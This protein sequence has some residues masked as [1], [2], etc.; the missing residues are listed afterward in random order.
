MLDLNV[1]E[2]IVNAVKAIGFKELTEVQKQVIP[3]VM[4][5]KNVVGTSQTGSGKTHSFLIPLFDQLRFMVC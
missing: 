5:G 2:Y 4:R 3:L 1:K